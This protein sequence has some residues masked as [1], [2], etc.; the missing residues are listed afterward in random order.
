MERKRF[1]GRPELVKSLVLLTLIVTSIVQTI[2]L[3]D[4]HPKYQSVQSETQVATVDTSLQRRASQLIIPAQ[5]VVHENNAVF[6]TKNTPKQITRVIRDAFEANEFKP[7]AAKNVPSL[8]TDINEALELVL[9]EPYYADTLSYIVPGSYSLSGKVPQRALLFVDGDVWKIRAIMSD[10]SIWEGRLTKVGNSDVNSLFLKDSSRAMQRVTYTDDRVNYIPVVGPEMNE[11]FAYDVSQIQISARL[12]WM[13]DTFFPGDPNVQEVDP[14]S[15]VG[16]LTNGISVAEYD[17]KLNASR[18]R[19]LSRNST[20]RESAIGL[21]TIVEFVNFHGGWVDE[22]SEGQGLSLRFDA[23][24]PANKGFETTVFRFHV[25]GYPVFSQRE[26]FINND[27]VDLSTLRVEND[28]AQ[29]RSITR[30]HL[31]IDRMISVG[32]TKLAG[33]QDVV[34]MLV[35]T[36][37][38]ENITEIRLGYEIEYNE[39][40]S[41]Y[42]TFS[43]NWFV[44]E[45]GRWIPYDKPG[46]WTE[47]MMYRGLE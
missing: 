22:T 20:E 15:S 39:D 11:L 16:A 40:T 28:G 30:H 25:N 45:A 2:I 23:I 27:A 9:P 18:Y 12:D 36:G 17:A 4:Y 19:N 29:V 46:D 1:W 6:A 42:V 10:Q 47:R 24:T 14:A 21:D 37:R 5:T 3:W 26:A 41:R 43:P 34:D 7:L 32:T 44:R 13:R 35:N 31:E 33:G 38:F 8:Y